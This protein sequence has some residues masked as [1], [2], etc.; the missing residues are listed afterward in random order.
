[1]TA[2]TIGR[3]VYYRPSQHELTTQR[4]TQLDTSDP[5]R[6]DIVYVDNV[7]FTVN[8]VVH[9]HLGERLLRS[10]VEFYE[11]QQDTGMAHAHWMP[12]QVAQAAQAAKAAPTP[13]APTAPVNPAPTAE[14]IAAAIAAAA[15][16]APSPT[17]A[18]TVA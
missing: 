5:F 13:P 10:E 1:M 14:E 18:P 4:I 6:A 15:Q 8:L 12:Y 7:N 17:E 9:D 16:P 3:V 11:T 2:P